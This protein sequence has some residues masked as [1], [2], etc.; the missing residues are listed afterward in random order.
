MRVRADMPVDQVP[1]GRG[2][3][4][5]VLGMIILALGFGVAEIIDAS[6]PSG[7][8][9]AHMNPADWVYPSDDVRTWLTAIG[10]ETLIACLLLAAR[11]RISVG[12]RALLLAGL[13]FCGLCCLGLFAMQAASPFIDYLVFMFF[14]SVFLGLFAIVSMVV[15]YVVRARA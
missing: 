12:F 3:A 11:T 9:G 13:F 8:R 1:R 10:C 7:Y 6:H 15:Y 5:A 4:V 14:A 2:W